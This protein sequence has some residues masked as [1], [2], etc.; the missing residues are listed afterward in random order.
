MPV[1]VK[2]GSQP[3]S[4][5]LALVW[6]TLCL[7]NYFS[8]ASDGNVN[9]QSLLWK[10]VAVPIERIWHAYQNNPKSQ[11]NVENPDEQSSKTQVPFA[12]SVQVKWFFGNPMCVLYCWLFAMLCQSSVLWVQNYL[13]M[14][15]D[16]LNSRG[17][18]D[19]LR[20]IAM[21]QLILLVVAIWIVV[22]TLGEVPYDQRL[23]GAIR[24]G[25]MPFGII[26]NGLLLRFVTRNLP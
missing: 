21:L 25:W 5:A 18:G 17:W 11:N 10:T 20:I 26:F 3:Q 4:P 19:G 1:P 7:L 6:I 24:Y 16:F 12:A 13:L 9:G 23:S 8:W 15:I 2:S 14:P 22:G